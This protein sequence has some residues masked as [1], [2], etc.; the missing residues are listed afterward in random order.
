MLD[1]VDLI[2]AKF[3]DLNRNS[4]VCLLSTIANTVLILILTLP[5]RMNLAMGMILAMSMR[6]SI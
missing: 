2:C 4:R 3:T 6:M 1:E 5:L